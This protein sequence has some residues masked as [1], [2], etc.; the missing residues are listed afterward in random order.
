MAELNI[1]IYFVWHGKDF[2]ELD[3]RANIYNHPLYEWGSQCNRLA[4][5]KIRN[6]PCGRMPI[7]TKTKSYPFMLVPEGPACGSSYDA[8]LYHI[9]LPSS[10]VWGNVYNILP[11]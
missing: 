1:K 10:L 11:G 3:L 2:C 7:L 5:L 9:L 4:V 8:R 6:G